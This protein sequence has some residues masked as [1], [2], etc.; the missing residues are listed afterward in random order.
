MEILGGLPLQGHHFA[1]FCGL[2]LILT[3]VVLLTSKGHFQAHDR[4]SAH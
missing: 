3:L 4:V 2:P 1:I